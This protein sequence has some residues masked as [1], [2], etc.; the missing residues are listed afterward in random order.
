MDCNT[1]LKFSCKNFQ[2]KFNKYFILLKE[3]FQKLSKTFQISQKGINFLFY[4]N[5]DLNDIPFFNKT[6]SL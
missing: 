3:L 5:V 2:L 1:I 6:V 4:Q